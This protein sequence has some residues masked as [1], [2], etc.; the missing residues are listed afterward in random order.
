MVTDKMKP[1][2]NLSLVPGT[3]V[4]TQS[5]PDQQQQKR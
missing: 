1:A 4:S 2:V 3:V 5:E